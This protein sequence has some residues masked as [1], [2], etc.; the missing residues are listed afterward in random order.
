[1]HSKSIKVTPKKAASKKKI[2][3]KVAKFNKLQKKIELLELEKTKLEKVLG[4][5]L[6]YHHKHLKPLEVDITQKHV[7]LIETIFKHVPSLKLKPKDEHRLTCFMID[8]I[9]DIYQRDELLFEPKLIQIYDLISPI[10][11]EQHKQNRDFIQRTIFESMFK[12]AGI[13]VDLDGINVNDLINMEPDAMHEFLK[14]AGQTE[15][16]ASKQEAKQAPKQKTKQEIA[17]EQ[18]AL[19][20]EKFAAKSLKDI[21]TNLAKI[22]HPD[23]ELDPNLKQ[24]KEDWMKK[25]SV[26]YKDK[27]LSTMLKIEQHWL[28][29]AK[30]NPLTASS[31]TFNLYSEYL[32]N[33]VSE[34]F[35]EI[36]YLKLHPRFQSIGKFIHFH[37][38]FMLF[39]LEGEAVNLDEHLYQIKEL[40]ATLNNTNIKPSAKGKKILK[41]VNENEMNDFD[42]FEDF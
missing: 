3:P 2:D 28:G 27:D 22:V 23:T 12:D 39:E 4:E 7:L 20:H 36:E 33:R 37:H 41:F 34:I 19:A 24:E 21:Y 17:K 18:A 31:A 16:N 13:E 25:L 32:N 10:T 40:I 26:A 14:K 9:E 5:A 1:M 11:F 42:I 6:E 30:F 8:L 38:S 15:E 35:A 29:E